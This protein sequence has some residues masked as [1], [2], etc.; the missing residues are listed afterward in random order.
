M[1]VLILS[2]C[3]IKSS[4]YSDKKLKS[5]RLSAAI[6]W[7]SSMTSNSEQSEVDDSEADSDDTFDFIDYDDSEDEDDDDDDKDEVISGQQT[8][9]CIDDG[10]EEKTEFLNITQPQT[11]EDVHQ[12]SSSSSNDYKSTYLSRAIQ[13]ILYYR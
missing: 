8:E 11:E 9:V 7:F 10:D 5:L 1:Q 3:G 2:N 13:S 4:L 12:S 6:T